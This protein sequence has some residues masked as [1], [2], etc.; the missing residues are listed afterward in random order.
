MHTD[1]LGLNGI[2][3]SGLSSAQSALASIDNALSSVSSMRANMGAVQN[4]LQYAMSN[5]QVTIE[6]YTA[7]ESVIRDVDMA[8]EMAN[9]TKNQI[10]VQTSMAMLAQ[11]NALPQSIVQLLR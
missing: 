6:N 2:D 5:L 3:L 9:F 10:L 7:S 1:T 4:K 8:S 11:A